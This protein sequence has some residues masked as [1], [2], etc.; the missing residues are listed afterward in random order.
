[1]CQLVVG[2]QSADAFTTDFITSMPRYPNRR[3]AEPC[4]LHIVGKQ[5]RQ[6]F[7][8]PC[9]LVLLEIAVN[10][11]M[12]RRAF[13][14]FWPPDKIPGNRGRNR[15]RPAPTAPNVVDLADP[16]FLSFTSYCAK[17][18]IQIEPVHVYISSHCRPVAYCCCS[19]RASTLARR[20]SSCI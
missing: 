1:M 4:I 9:Q 20:I 11:P 6:C 18:L 7:G 8:I 3:I 10:A 14:V 2:K 15:T 5:P 19:L 12:G 16:R 13:D 17:F